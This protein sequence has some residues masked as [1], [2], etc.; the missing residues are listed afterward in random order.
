VYRYYVNHNAQPNGDHEVHR[1]DCTYLPSNRIDLGIF[2]S[3]HDAVRAAKKHHSQ[4]NGCAFCSPAC[5]T[6]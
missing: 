6:Q 3:C 1:D 2:T 5:H 4:V